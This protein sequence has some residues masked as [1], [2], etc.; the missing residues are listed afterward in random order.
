[1]PD[2]P[3][4]SQQSGNG[5]PYHQIRKLYG[6]DSVINRVAWSPKEN[7]LASTSFDKTV[8]L[9]DL[10]E[11]GAMARVLEGHTDWVSSVTWSPT[12]DA[13]ASGSG[14]GTI[15]LWDARRGQQLGYSLNGHTRAVFDVAWC[16]GDANLL[17]SAS[18]DGSIAVWDVE[19]RT[20]V[21]LFQDHNGAVCCVAWSPDG[22]WLASGSEDRTIRIWDVFTSR[23]IRI[24]EGHAGAVYHLR[25]SPDGRII[26]SASADTTVRFWGKRTGVL[27]GHTDAVTSVSLSADGQFLASKSLDGTVRFWRCDNWANI[28][29]FEEEG[30][31]Y[32]TPGLAFHPRQ[33]ILA[34]LGF[35]DHM[36]RI[37]RFDLDALRN[38]K[39]EEQIVQYTNAKV[40]IVGDSG[41]GK[42][43]LAE[44]LRGKPF[45]PTDSTH[46][47][48]VWRF[49]HEEFVR[50]NGLSE[51]H[52][53]LLWDMAGQPGYRLIH[54]LHLNEVVVA[55]IVFDTRSETDPL[56]GVR[57]WDRA[58]R[59]A[60]MVRSSKQ[61]M[62]LKTFLIA[63]RVDRGGVG[64]S[65]ERVNALIRDL[66]FHHYFETSA[67]EGTNVAELN[68]AIR[69]AIDW[70]LLPKVSS[71]KLFLSI[72]SF[73][74]H[75]RE[76]GELLHRIESLYDTF[77]ESTKMEDTEDLRKQFETCLGLVEAQGLLRRFS[78]GDLVLL[79]PE[80]LDAYA[81]AIIAKARDEADGVGMIAEEDVRAGRFPMPQ[82]ERIDDKRQ[83]E[84]LLIAT[85]E[86]L[87][88]HEIAMR[89]TDES[90]ISHLV[91]PSQS[92]R[93]YSNIPEP[94]SRTAIWTFEGAVFNIYTT[95][96]VRLWHTGLFK[97]KDMYENAVFYTVDG[98]GVCRMFL[99][100]LEEG[101]AELRLYFDPSVSAEKQL[102]IQE[103]VSVH[104][105]RRALTDTVK[106]KRIFAC[107]NP[108][109][110]T[111]LSDMQVTKRREL[112]Y[113][114][115]D[116]P[117][118]GTRISLVET[119]SRSQTGLLIRQGVVYKLDREADM[120]RRK[121][122]AVSV[123]Q[124][125]IATEDYDVF[126]CH[127]NRDK[128][129]VREIAQQLKE[130][131]ILPWL[132]VAE[133]AGGD[134]WE[135]KL[136]K[137]IEKCKT[138]AFFLGSNGVG[139]YQRNELHYALDLGLRVIPV[140]LPDAPRMA[141][142]PLAIIDR[143]R[144]DFRLKTLNPIEELVRGITTASSGEKSAPP[145]GDKM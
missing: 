113:D 102:Y 133:L 70:D 36:I 129:A 54:Q 28:G 89:D 139:P 20:P 81:S 15:R 24:L 86:D 127:N 47:R 29:S 112:G 123:L 96:V 55:L 10:R 95:L 137:Q 64:V 8:K 124:G 6:H 108:E 65:R 42:T 66:K 110:Q 142:L 67:K 132:D 3:D 118:C 109:C 37:W 75:I 5:K 77:V 91:F 115:M 121:Q 40:V 104:L 2:H 116:C 25:W 16:P 135:E 4:D 50:G 94:D 44:V 58:L 71:T 128:A 17:A 30:S 83:E 18:A 52:E 35:E 46:G 106:R 93:S 98:G 138:L 11:R 105:K 88:S 38:A 61:K 23:P 53:I 97:T 34:S 92:T 126:L 1:M 56:T 125:K 62:P 103:Y 31:S 13:L 134:D 51:T 120:Q 143:H 87:L 107:S 99:K 130:Y 49:D 111:P 100:P 9:W 101:Q 21:R 27:E 7:V 69:K 80:L 19:E 79:Q 12:G 68:A 41:V 45:R 114:W 63:G 84:L 117:V 145:A 131:G 26:V 73:L 32:W 76:Q 57:H 22:R 141:R 59:H 119:S 140:L 33:P 136:Q 60:Q 122:M 14:D 90:G 72:K 39:L 144:V 78:F 74:T 43:S 85:V 48:H 82:E